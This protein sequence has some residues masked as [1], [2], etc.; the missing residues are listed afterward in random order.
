[1]DEGGNHLKTGELGEV[2]IQGP[3]V[4]QGYENNPEANAK[5]FTNG[6]FRTGDQGKI[7]ADGYLHLTARI[8]ELIVRGGEKIAPLEIDEVLLSHPAVAE[9]VAFGAPHPAWGEE[10]AVAVVLREPQDG[11]ESVLLSYCRE[12][13]ADFK[14]PR[15]IH[16]VE[17]IPRTATGKIQRRVVAATLSGTQS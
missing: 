2:V 10:V 7:D 13:L 12:R 17:A 6:W 8:K 1:M 11:A 9:A 5:S 16:I 14:C 3:N 4:I 15:K